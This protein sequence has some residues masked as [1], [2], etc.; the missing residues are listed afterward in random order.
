MKVKKERDYKDEYEKFQSG[1]K[2]KKDR[3]ARNKRR[4]QFEL[5][6]K[7][8]KGDGKDIHH[9]TVGGKVRTKV[10]TASENRGKKE[11]SRVKGYKGLKVKK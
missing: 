4:R 11:K 3:A 8:R 1:G 5:G 2:H 7:V 10:M 9:Y 6:G